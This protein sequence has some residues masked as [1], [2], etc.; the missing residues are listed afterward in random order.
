MVVRYRDDAL[1]VGSISGEAVL[2]PRGASGSWSA[3]PRYEVREKVPGAFW[4]LV[5]SDHELVVGA[6]GEAG[7]VTVTT[8]SIPNA[9]AVHVLR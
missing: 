2:V 1:A 7:P 3:G 4:N 9:G 8:K 5:L 6:S